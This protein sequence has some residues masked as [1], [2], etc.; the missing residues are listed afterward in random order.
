M[1]KVVKVIGKVA[2]VVASVASFIPGVGQVVA[3]VAGAVAL[4]ASLLTGKPK[5]PEASP[6]D[7]DR[8][9]A[10]IDTR[11]ARK[12]VY[13][14]TAMATDI[15]DQEFTG[16]DQEFLHRFIVVAAHKVG[17]IEQ[18]YFDDKL[19][20]TSA[21]G[22][23]GEF[24]GYL[25]VATRLEGSA[26]NAINIS[27]RMGN[28]RRYTGLAYV[29]L[30]FRLTGT[31]KNSDSPFSQA[32]PT[33]LTIIGD[34]MPIYDP[35]KDP[36]FGGVGSHRA[37]DQS[38]WDWGVNTYRNPPL[39]LL[40]FLIGWRINGKISV[41][42]GIPIERIN[43]ASFIAA[44]NLCDE[45]VSLAAGGT[46]PR[47]RTDGIF[48]EADAMDLVLDQFK[49][50]MNAILDDVDGQI[51]L[52]V[53]YNDLSV[54]RAAFTED[55]VLG[56]VNW[57]PQIKLSDQFNIIRGTYTDASVNS[58]YQSVSYP[59]VEIASEDGIDRVE[60]INYPLVQSASQAQRLANQRLQ[61][62]QFGGV[63]AA[64]FQATAWKVQKGDVIEQSFPSL[65]FDDKLF[66][67]VDTDVQMNGV[68]NMTLRE[69]DAALYAWDE[70]E[71]PAVVPAPPDTYN[72]ALNPLFLDIQQPSYGDGT[73]IDDL[74]PAA[75]GAD[76]T[77]ANTAAAIAG[78][79]ALATQNTADYGT[80][81]VGIPTELAD[82]NSGE[83]SVLEDM[84]GQQL[85]MSLGGVNA[86][87]VNASFALATAIVS[88]AP[89]TS[90]IS[91]VTGYTPHYVEVSDVNQAWA[92][93][94]N[95]QIGPN[96]I[97]EVAA[98]YERLGADVGVRIGFYSW[99]ETGAVVD[100]NVQ[101]STFTETTAGLHL[102]RTRIG[103]VDV[104]AAD[105]DLKVSPGATQFRPHF[106]SNANSAAPHRLYSLY[107]YKV[108]GFANWEEVVGPDRPEDNADVTGANT[109]AA[110]V[111]Q[112]SLATAN[113]VGVPDITPGDEISLLNYQD[114]NV[115]NLP[116]VGGGQFSV[117]SG[118]QVGAI[119]ILLPQAWTN[120][121]L[122]FEVQVYNYA[123]GAVQ[124]YVIGGY[125]ATSGRWLNQ[126]AQVV[127][128]SEFTQPVRFGYRN[129]KAAIWIGDP[130]TVWEFPRVVISNVIVAHV[131]F[132]VAD[133][134]T[135]WDISLDTVAAANDDGSTLREILEPTP[136]D[137][138]FGVNARESY[139]GQM[140][141]VANFRT[142]QGTAG[143]IAGQGALATLNEAAWGTDIAG[144]P[145]ELT[146]GRIT[147]GLTATGD[148][149]RD[150]DVSRA[151]SSDLLRFNT[152]GLFV[153]DLDADITL[154]NT[155]AGIIGQ[156]PAA[157]DNN[158]EAAADVTKTITGPSA[159]NFDFDSDGVIKPGQLGNRGVVSIVTS[160]GVTITSGVVW[161]LA[162][163]SGS[164]AGASP[165]VTGTGSGQINFGSEPQTEGR[166]E[167]TG[168]LSGREYVT[169]IDITKTQDP[170]PTGGGGGGSTN[171]TGSAS[172]VIASGGAWVTIF[173]ASVN[174]AAAATEVD[175]TANN[176]T[177]VPDGSIG[178]SGNIQY[179]WQRENSPGGGVWSDVGAVADSNPDPFIFSEGGFPSPQSGGISC[180]R[181]D[182]GRTAS[183]TYSYRL[184]ARIN[185]GT[186]SSCSASGAVALN[187]E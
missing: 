39:Q 90:E 41:G 82:I 76:V 155:A 170:P 74:Q 131:A 151:D 25:T 21:G 14:R 158:I 123:V 66:R 132:S 139:G 81:V 183:T 65:G 83:G 32:V 47:Y 104:P 67:V 99:D 160:A 2:G 108:S 8:L 37:D 71:A 56:A 33:R 84:A 1:S 23:Q 157:T 130:G 121:M 149:A 22:V 134:Q 20:W 16:T 30:R 148:L 175:L 38:T 111:G 166:I 141:T 109:A 128:G 126:S 13:G 127:G 79:G 57:S 11:A 119:R 145:A 36:T 100:S 27:S 122:R 129:G 3:A 63:M 172:G 24:S 75:A 54:P 91:N 73:P 72:F 114:G 31:D 163:K 178:Q 144:R 185:T 6:S 112:G 125:T 156:A 98:V 96:E 17:S 7:R 107:F 146:D 58:L 143:A 169:S 164:Y 176:H 161:A 186:I 9:V 106:R 120:T 87:I 136:G 34:A 26:A 167:L 80:D 168:T 10:N 48:S 113:D 43:V 62:M 171:V 86:D 19:A 35:R 159:I 137:M 52:Q 93:R 51:R 116:I 70:D 60:T 124:T 184:R 101:T 44:A 154:G 179:Q 153:G 182:S 42:K 92:N 29:H 117:S 53:L 77:A 68:V 89:G 15:R 173:S 135:G 12:I 140:A 55:D 50:S 95:L 49:S 133:W 94:R 5:S 102:Q 59:E 85:G 110:I 88:P 61:R 69:E 187:G 97:W 147:A 40:N 64:A 103:G 46:E 180:T 118:N 78:Q 150:I 165:T 162:V 174:T 177:L 4:G 181:T 152:G 28:T 105:V 45:A 115:V 142:D 138:V 18:I